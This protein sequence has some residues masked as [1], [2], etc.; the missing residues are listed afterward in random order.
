MTATLTA[1]FA[2]ALP[3]GWVRLPARPE[4]SA[5]R[6]IDAIVRLALPDDLP[7]D[8]A[9]PMR[10]HLR[11][12]LA[13]AVDEAGRAGAS[14][15]YLPA[16]PTGGPALPVSLSEAEVD[17]ESE[18]EPV[19]LIASLLSEAGQLDGLRD[20][21]GA[22][23]ARTVETVSSDQSEGAWERIWSRRVVYTVAVPHRPG[24]WVVLT[25]TAAFGDDASERLADA[26]VELF[27]AIMTTFRWTDVPG[28]EPTP[29][30]TAIAEAEA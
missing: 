21:D 14:A 7:R 6:E 24:R 15:V 1:S 4:H 16:A 11:R 23:A 13:D 18:S 12:R 29:I 20:V 19:R 26:L 28:S 10:R 25:F 9:E 8:S 17:D 22:A 2:L 5:D 30:E 27:D 3:A